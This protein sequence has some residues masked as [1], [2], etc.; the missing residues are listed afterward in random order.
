MIKLDEKIKQKLAKRE[1]AQLKKR[2]DDDVLLLQ[3]DSSRPGL[4]R[5]FT[6]TK[7][8]ADMEM[9]RSVGLSRTEL[10]TSLT[11]GLSRTSK[12]GFFGLRKKGRN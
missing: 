2:P 10:S 6:R 8:S 9:S 11:L 12:K 7:Q 4:L 3:G 5:K 1:R